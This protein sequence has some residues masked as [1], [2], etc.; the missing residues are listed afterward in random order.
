MK[1]WAVAVV[2]F[3]VGVIF[4]GGLFWSTTIPTT[5]KFQ[6]VEEVIT[7]SAETVA[8]PIELPPIELVTRTVTLDDGNTLTFQ[9]AEPFEVAVAAE[10]MGKAR[11][12]AMS[13]EGR[14]FVP[15]LVNYNLSREG[16]I[17]I[18]EDFNE[19][20]KRFETKHTYLS[21][22]RGPN[23][24]A[25]YT[26]KNGQD[27]IYIALTA[28]LIR[29]PYEAGDT[30]PSSEPEVI[31]EFPNTQE[32][33][34]TSVVWHITRTLLFQDDRLYIAIGSGCNS[35]EQ[36]DQGM[37]GMVVSMN[38]D[39]T[40]EKMYADGLRNAVGLEWTGDSLYTT[41][42]GV[43]HLG[44][45]AP[46]ERMFRL[47]EGEHYGWPYCYEVDGEIRAERPGEWERSF[48]CKDAP[49]SFVAFPPHSAPLGLAYF[50]DFNPTLNRAFLIALHG[51]F[52]PEVSSGYEIVRVSDEGETEVFM[53]GFQNDA[54]EVFA[55][56]VDI[57][58]YDEDSFFFTDD[59]GGRIFYVYAELEASL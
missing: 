8:E 57:L 52:E 34:Q 38:P 1:F 37:R 7:S 19:E 26:D 41:A 39:G 31:T 44:P 56:P 47:S 59:F 53:T 25:F 29:Y 43:D 50:S 32:P 30:E 40:D 5:E 46:D 14:M 27:W 55:R 4:T 24:V 2:A 20:A 22:L 15:D 49:H 48:S 36:F 18:L 51:S 54:Y 6:A 3:L 21:S 16:K 17:Y 13:P 10:D 33:N 12:M 28:N 58:Q 23:S 35:C 45:N 11:F 42:N 9:L